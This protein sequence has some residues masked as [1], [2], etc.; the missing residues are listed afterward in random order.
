MNQTERRTTT[1]IY[2]YIDLSLSIYF[3]IGLFYPKVKILCFGK[4][5]DLLGCKQCTLD[6]PS[7]LPELGQLYEIILIHFPA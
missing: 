1:S 6:L 5:S 4:S 3:F 2:I 7:L